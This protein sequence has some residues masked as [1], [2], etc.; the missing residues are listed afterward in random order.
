MYIVE[1]IVGVGVGD[2]DTLGDSEGLRLAAAAAAPAYSLVIGVDA[3]DKKGIILGL[4]ASY[5]SWILAI[6]LRVRGEHNRTSSKHNMAGR[7]VSQFRKARLPDKISTIY[8]HIRRG[9]YI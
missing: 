4:I 7:M 1:D 6:S 5:C 8:I 9:G 3:P 2:D